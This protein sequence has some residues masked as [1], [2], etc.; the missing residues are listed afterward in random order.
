MLSGKVE[1]MIDI[2]IAIPTFNSEKYITKAIQSTLIQS[3]GVIPVYVFDN[4]SSDNTVDICKEFPH[5][6]VWRNTMNEGF[7]KNIRN[8]FYRPPHKYVALLCSD[9]WFES[10]H[11][12]AAIFAFQNNKEVRYYFSYAKLIYEDNRNVERVFSVA[13]DTNFIPPMHLYPRLLKSHIIPISSLVIH[14]NTLQKV[15][16]E[17]WNRKLSDW[18]LTIHISNHYAGWCE[19]QPTVCYLQ[20]SSS[21]GQSWYLEKD[22]SLS[23]IDL[24]FSLLDRFSL[25]QKKETSLILHRWLEAFII[26]IHKRENRVGLDSINSELDC[27]RKTIHSRMKHSLFSGIFLWLS[28]SILINFIVFKQVRKMTL[29]ILRKLG[30]GQFILAD[31]V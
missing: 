12:E 5:V 4:C 7:S 17:C 27:I 23:R 6:T 25:S 20:R 11:I 10:N 8:C 21:M 15:P 30:V 13:V 16:E 3:A 28:K 22:Y 24:L 18:E 31:T 2:A 9:D 14:K 29:T 26:A 1:Q 19:K